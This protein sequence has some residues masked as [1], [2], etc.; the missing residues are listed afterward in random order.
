MSNKNPLAR[1]L[2]DPK[3]LPVELRA[4]GR[5]FPA[6]E[7][8]DIIEHAADELEKL[9]AALKDALAMVETFASGAG[10]SSA[11]GAEFNR[12]KAI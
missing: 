7:D 9:R 3:A 11:G 4:I 10:F 8:R 2:R 6:C 12:L 1:N 5:R